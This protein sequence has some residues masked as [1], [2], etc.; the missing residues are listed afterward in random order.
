[1]T[2]G[3]IFACF[4]NRT[5]VIYRINISSFSWSL[6]SMIR[7]FHEVVRRTKFLPVHSHPPP[8][9]TWWC[10]YLYHVICGHL[11]NIFQITRNS[12]LYHFKWI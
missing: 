8:L 12:I 2:I 11:S 10:G 5:P 1:M 3:P 6:N 7:L 9:I 4:S